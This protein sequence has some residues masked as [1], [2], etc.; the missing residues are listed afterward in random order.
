MLYSI[1]EAVAFPSHCFI[2]YVLLPGGFRPA[3]A[4]HSRCGRAPSRDVRSSGRTSPSVPFLLRPP[5][6]I[7]RK[8]TGRSLLLFLSAGC[9][10]P[11]GSP[12]HAKLRSQLCPASPGGVLLTQIGSFFIRPYMEA[13]SYT[14]LCGLLRR[15][16]GFALYSCVAGSF[17]SGSATFLTLACIVFSLFYVL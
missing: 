4:G 17:V 10:N 15:C 12:A 6:Q 1:P 11:H 16:S 5:G 3:S 9:L 13:L 14:G 2:F 7:L 8:Y